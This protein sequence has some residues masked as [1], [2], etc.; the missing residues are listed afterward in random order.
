M[1]K[2]LFLCALITSSLIRAAGQSELPR[3][4]TRVTHNR[5]QIAFILAGRVWLVDRRGGTARRLTKTDHEENNPVFSPDGK[6]LA[7]SRFN[8]NDWDVFVTAADG[9]TEPRR[10]TMMP[11]ND[12][13]VTWTP[14]SSEIVFETSRDE[15]AVYRLY[16]MRVDQPR[17]AEGLPLP[18]G[19]DGSYSADGKYFAYNPRI[20][21]FGEWRY[22]R[23][24]MTAP[25][26][27]TDL[28]A[29]TTEKLSNQYFNDK[30]PMWI[31]DKIY[32]V[33]DRT[34]VFNLF[35]HDRNTKTS[36]QMTKFTGQGIRTAFA[37]GDAISF[38]RDGKVHLFDL[39]TNRETVVR[40]DISPDR[41]ELAPR[42]VNAL[43]FLDNLTPSA[44]GEKLAIN[45]RGEVLIFDHSNGGVKN[46]TNTA[47]IAERYPLISPDK[48]T[49]AYFS[50][51]TGEYQLHLRSLENDSV[52]KIPVEPKPSFYRLLAWSPD[53]KRVV[54][55]D[56]RLNLW[57]AETGGGAAVK[58]DSSTY[59]AQEEW[60]AGFSPDSRFLTYAKRLKN[61]AGTIFIYDL[62]RKKSFQITDG[63]THTE[64]PVFDASG[65][66]L[67]F[68]SSP[69][70]LTSEFR[71]G[72]LNGVLAR[73]LV[74]RQAQGFVLGQNGRAPHLPNR[75]LDPEAKVTEALPQTVIDFENPGQRFFSLPVPA[76]DY[77]R[78]AAGRAGK[79]F[80]VVGEWGDTPGNFDANQTTS[81][82]LADLTKPADLPKIVEN[83]SGYE[84]TPNGG[85]LLYAKGRDWFLVN[86]EAAPKPDEGK[87]DLSRMEVRV[88]PPEEWR[89]MF[90]ESMR[91]MR[92]WFYDP[93]YHGQNLT[94]LE[95]YYAAYLPGVTRR[96]DL[97]LLI[98]RMLGSVSVSH[99]GVGGGDAPP[100]AGPGNNIG[101]LGADFAIENNRYRFKKVFRSTSYATPNGGSRG[102]LGA[103]VREGD[104]LLEV[105]GKSVEAEQNIL[106]YFEN[107]VNRPTKITVSVNP[108]GSNPRTVTVYPAPGENRL[109]LANRAEQNRKLVE[110]R[111]GGKLGYIFIEDYG[112]GIMNAIRGLS[113]YADKQGIIIDQR[114]NGGG[115]TP[116]YLI[117]WMQRK[118]LY[119]YLFRDG[120][121]IATPVNPAPAV[122]V[123]IVNEFNGSAAETGA[124]MFKLANVGAVVGKRT[125]GGGIGPYFFTPRLVDG[126]RIQLPNRAAYKS[127]GTSWGIENI[128]VEPDFDVE[129]MPRDYLAGRD[130]QLEKAIEVALRQIART[131]AVKTKRPAFPTHPG[132]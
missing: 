34:G 4:F 14:D 46:I 74:V 112:P 105:N 78:L 1:L 66:Y 39:T 82:Y 107:T 63:V 31:G 100:L 83:V 120:D 11:E 9:G 96:R 121:D 40:I 80:L 8:G 26:W 85:R 89:Q 65:K 90:R 103:S 111:S 81:I 13:V 50:D 45:A 132:N 58:V 91:I 113:G 19:F 32:F 128:G 76:R 110:Q 42:N 108:D 17:L 79:L 67:Y 25:I 124:L 122:K 99:L 118:P 114:F 117:E 23:G 57:V 12:L 68:L 72:V 123:M 54:F 69:N 2:Y 127:D 62:G 48:K 101:L 28:R 43:R 18:Q 53:S 3:L 95:N 77:A 21:R 70:A 61:R 7:F 64:S 73:P 22:Y 88:N 84:V 59:S 97:N 116:D 98:E 24:G 37:G 109:R 6:S 35:V 38:I 10:I 131:P 49:V 94:A 115:I 15:E 75:Q 41:A 44:D 56:R 16:K 86:A 55:S 27:I 102:P 106:S 51:E 30:N 119:H 87:L 52:K 130:P 126:G 20:W 36:R 92:D 60:S 5:N 93:N 129:I 125:S 33:S 104:Y 47:N 29:G 71:W